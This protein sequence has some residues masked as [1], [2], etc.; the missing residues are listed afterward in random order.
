MADL[1]ESVQLS[2]KANKGRG[3]SDAS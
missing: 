2:L 1:P 3:A